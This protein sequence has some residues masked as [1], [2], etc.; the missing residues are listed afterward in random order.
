VALKLGTEGWRA[1]IGGDFT[2]AHARTFARGLA[3]WLHGR[4]QA[5]G[6]VVVGYDTRFLSDRAAE[7][8]AAVLARA[9]IPARL[10]THP[11]PTPVVSFAVRALGASAGLMITASHNP[12]EY[13]GIKVKGAH[14][15]PL[16]GPELATLEEALAHRSPPLPVTARRPTPYDPDPAYLA[17]LRGLIDFSRF[18]GTGLR[19]VVDPLHGAARHYLRRLLIPA[20]IAVREIRATP[21]PRFGGVNPEPI[22]ANL[23]ALS[24]A[25]RS[26]RADLGLAT[27]GDGDRLGVVDRTGRFQSPQVIYALLLDYLARERNL[28]GGVVKTVSTTG[29]IDRLADQY[30]L[31][32]YQTPVGFKHISRLFV[33]GTAV[34]GGEESGGVGVSPHLP[35][36]DGIFAGLLLLEALATR[37]KTLPQLLADL[38]Q[39]TGPH[40]YARRDVHLPAGQARTVFRE[41]ARLAAAPSEA[42]PAV[43]GHSVSGV[44][45]LDGVKLRLDDGGWLLLRSSGTEPVLRIYA[46]S[47]S[48]PEVQRLLEA[49]EALLVRTGAP[50]AAGT[51]HEAS[52][53]GR[54]P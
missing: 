29:M 51:Y 39:V 53:R 35:E 31:P 32:L 11:V 48:P 19:V 50:R 26:F 5:A 1:R 21:D 8:V 41:L 3:R 12:P 6:G 18:A 15:G 14:G 10:C 37:G 42:P 45:T 22:A 13:N 9:G 4:D 24:R 52:E 40:A 28:R 16:F 33:D 36:R 34:I 17:H 47:A 49:G 54:T 43:A 30:G 44:E 27:D 7:E 38:E 23:A 20:G 2:L 25:V 46:E